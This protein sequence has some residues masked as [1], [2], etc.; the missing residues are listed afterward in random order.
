MR[1]WLRRA[2]GAIGM[3]FTWG[4]VWSAAGV[5][6]RWVF[7]VDSDLPLPLLLGGLGFIAGITFSGL[8]ALA[9]GRRRLDRISLPRS[10]AWG[11]MAGVLLSVPF[12]GGASPGWGEML[13][14]SAV[15][16]VS[17]AICASGSL[18]LARRPV[19]RGL[20]EHRADTTGTA[21]QERRRVR[22][23]GD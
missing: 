7:G 6:L 13:A 23:R 17:S 15:F 4:V 14:T 11:A 20:P 8:L 19:R 9:E 1:T 21:N 16:A 18:A 10:A 5:F 3:G 22:A 12:V 2:R